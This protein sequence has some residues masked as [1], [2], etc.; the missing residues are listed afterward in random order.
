[1]S[2]NFLKPLIWCV[3]LA[4]CGGGKQNNQQLAHTYFKMAFSDIAEGSN[5]AVSLKRALVNINK[6]LA[7]DNHPEYYAFKGAILFKLGDYEQSEVC[8]Q[9]ALAC[10]PEAGLRAE[11]SNNRACLLAHRKNY[12]QAQEVWH[13]LIRDTSYQT[14]E[15]AWVN[16]GKMYVEEKKF[17]DAK[18]AFAQAVAVAPSYV[19]AHFYLSIVERELGNRQHARYEAD[20]VLKMEPEHHGAHMLMAAID[21]VPHEVR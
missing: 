7:S 2:M 10:Q 4:S 6:A 3:I 21:P 15:V 8:Y 16:L 11:I 18:K 12:A 9:Q 20:M 17:Q 1:M 19:D 14:P 5:P 13:A